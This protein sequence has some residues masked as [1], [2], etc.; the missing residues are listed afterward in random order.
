MNSPEWLPIIGIAG[1]LLIAF[2]VIRPWRVKRA[3]HKIMR[4]FI[5]RNAISEKNAITA[6]VLGIKPRNILRDSFTMKDYKRDALDFLLRVQVIARTD[7]NRF[8]ISETG[9]RNTHLY[10][11]R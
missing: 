6:D 11:P 9:L 5:E 10:K 7:D 2:F 1:V 4:V 3:V 8:Y